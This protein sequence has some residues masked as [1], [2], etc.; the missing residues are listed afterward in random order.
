MAASDATSA[1]AE[2]LEI[3]V[4]WPDYDAVDVGAAL[5]DAGLAVRLAPKLGRRSPEELR[6]L[7]CKAAGAIV[8]TDPFDAEVLDGC[9]A[10]RVIARVGVGVDSIDLEAAT[11][12]GVAVTVTPGANEV[13]VADHT[14]ALMLA[15]VRRI[16]AHDAGVRRGEWNRTGD[17]TP[18]LLSGATVG[19]I[20]YGRIGRLVAER[21]HGFGVQLLVSDPVAPLD[22]GVDAV[23]LDSLL[24][25]SD[26]VSLHVPLQAGTVGL[27]GARELALMPS[28]AVL[29]NTSRGGVVDERALVDALRA[30]R[31]RAASLDVFADEPPIASPLLAL[32]NVTLSPHVSGLSTES[33]A[34]MTRRAT[35]SV[36]DVLSGRSP[37]DLA[38][39]AVLETAAFR[40]T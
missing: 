19:L 10:L 18:W 31:L 2:A 39:P 12:R 29:V 33:I 26:V 4:T 15:A 34:E 40:R 7:A 1:G 5:R 6:A 28:R 30:G 17:H 11:A 35:A 23:T 27:I 21:L 13:T 32:P 25:A 22:D 24:A 38:N 3:L 36:I 16:C 9:P 14:L 37:A 20:G 8:S